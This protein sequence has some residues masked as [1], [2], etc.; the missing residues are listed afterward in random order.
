MGYVGMR[1]VVQRAVQQ[2]CGKP[3]QQ[4]EAKSP[5][6][7]ERYTTSEVAGVVEVEV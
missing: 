2:R 7:H 3:F 4:P 6:R 5:G 1:E